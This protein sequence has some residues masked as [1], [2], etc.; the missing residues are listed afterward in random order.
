MA[1]AVE[2]KAKQFFKSVVNNLWA[3]QSDYPKHK[4]LS[5]FDPTK[6]EATAAPERN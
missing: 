6:I 4:D 3:H 1:A 5:K 2:E